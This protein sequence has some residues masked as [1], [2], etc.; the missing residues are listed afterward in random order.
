M[1]TCRSPLAR[2]K[3]SLPE[4]TETFGPLVGA[5]TSRR[6]PDA[7]IEVKAASS[8]PAH[9][10]RVFR[11]AGPCGTEVYHEFVEGVLGLLPRSGPAWD[12][13]QYV[14]RRFL[15]FALPDACANSRAE[16]CQRPCGWE[17]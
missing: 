7:A 11:I 13:V 12:Y 8:H 16:V 10:Q 6:S 3:L 5:T 1:D 17:G 2:D 15:G 14:R 9:G 4:P